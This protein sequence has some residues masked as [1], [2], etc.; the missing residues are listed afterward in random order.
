M[1]LS[2]PNIHIVNY[3]EIVLKYNTCCHLMYLIPL[4]N[5]YWHQGIK[6]FVLQKKR[7]YQ[8]KYKSDPIL[9]DYCFP[10]TSPSKDMNN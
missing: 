5:S 10:T 9:Y 6:S 7:S 2:E 3:C 4:I 8:S 1:L